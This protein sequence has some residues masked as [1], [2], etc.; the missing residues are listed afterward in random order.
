M[1]QNVVTSLRTGLFATEMMDN[2][3]TCQSSEI[4]DVRECATLVIL[5]NLTAIINKKSVEVTSTSH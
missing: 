5:L 4:I 3:S 1:G 2:L